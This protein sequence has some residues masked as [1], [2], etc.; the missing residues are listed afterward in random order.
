[1]VS[2]GSLGELVTKDVVDRFVKNPVSSQEK[3]QNALNWLEQMRGIS[4]E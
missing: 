4:N 1:L 3:K 2:Q